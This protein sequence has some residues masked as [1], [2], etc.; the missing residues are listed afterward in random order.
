MVVQTQTSNSTL[1]RRALLGN[2]AFSAVSG[3]ALIAG[4][5]PIATF[6]GLHAPFVLA[7]TGVVLMLYAASLYRTAT[8]NPIDAREALLAVGLDV[9]WVIGSALILLGGW[10]PLTGEGR[11]TVAIVAEVVAIFAVLQ[12]YGVRVMQRSES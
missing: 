1:L 4:A 7:G 6:L 11:W 10:L 2:S 12:Y 5:Q 9:A 8:Q 3:V